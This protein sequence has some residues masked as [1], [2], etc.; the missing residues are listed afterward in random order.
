[1]YAV[2]A[3][4]A[5]GKDHCWPSQSWLADKMKVS[6]R[7]VQNYIAELEKHGFLLIERHPGAV[8]RYYFVKADSV[9]LR[10]VRPEISSPSASVLE[11]TNPPSSVHKVSMPHGTETGYA[12]FSGGREDASEG[13]ANFADPPAKSAQGY[14]KIADNINNNINI[15]TNPPL[16]PQAAPPSLPSSV[17]ASR[18]EGG[19]SALESCEKAFSRLYEVWPRKEARTAALRVWKKLWFSGQLPPCDT[20]FQQVD[21]LK[22]HDRAWR[23]GFPPYLVNWLR[24]ERWRDAPVEAHPVPNSAQAAEVASPAAERSLTDKEANFERF[25]A[26][27]RKAFPSSRTGQQ[28]EKGRESFIRQLQEQYLPGNHQRC[29][30]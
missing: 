22:T 3:S 11:A 15:N 18:V 17:C 30:C 10:Q 14:A 20:L 4:C 13:Y 2:L 7:S 1:L 5:F 26:L 8:L 6:G 21:F 12:N 19:A 24:D 28:P 9:E 29:D 27:F 23:R 16:P 25:Q